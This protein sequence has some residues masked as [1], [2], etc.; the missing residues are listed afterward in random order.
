[1]S[2]DPGM[3]TLLASTT[4]TQSRGPAYQRISLRIPKIDAYFTGT[5]GV[6]TDRSIVGAHGNDDIGLPLCH[7]FE[8]LALVKSHQ[9][10]RPR[11]FITG[12]SL[13]HLSAVIFIIIPSPDAAPSF[14]LPS[15]PFLLLSPGDLLAALLLARLHRHPDD[16]AGAVEAAVASLQG[17]LKETIKGWGA[18]EALDPNPNPAGAAAA[19]AVERTA[20]VCRRRELKLIQSQACLAT[21]EILIRATPYQDDSPTL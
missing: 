12:L 4:K 15:P 20:E 17:C 8:A 9:A 19:P 1:M 18:E 21:P 13:M 16:L 5:G 7:D 6:E 11:C 3:I 10:V 14:L 2:D